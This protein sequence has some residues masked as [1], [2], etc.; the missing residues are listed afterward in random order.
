MCIGIESASETMLSRINKQIDA[1]SIGKKLQLLIDHGIAPRTSFIVG[2]PGEDRNG[3][4]S[5]ARFIRGL[6]KAY[7]KNLHLLVFPYRRDIA[8][9][10]AEF[11]ICKSI[12]TVADS[13]IPSHDQEFRQWAFAM[14]YLLN[15]Y[16]ETLEPEDQCSMVDTLIEASPRT[17]VEMARN[18]HGEM[19]PQFCGL[20]RYFESN[21]N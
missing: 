17:V 4:I 15:V 20:Q 8:A 9:K 1:R 19:P 21:R 10:A 11:E 3:V 13:I 16:H 12:E 2:L 7:G 6:I 18:Y 14:V 5:T